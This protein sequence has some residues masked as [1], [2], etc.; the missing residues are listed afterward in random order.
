MARCHRY[1]LFLPENMETFLIET[2][3]GWSEKTGIY[4]QVSN[5]RSD[6]W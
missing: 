4:L 5:G 2:R 6:R 3:Q 1:D